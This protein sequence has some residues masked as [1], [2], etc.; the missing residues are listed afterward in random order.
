MPVIV[1]HIDLVDTRPDRSI[2]ADSSGAAPQPDQASP[3][4]D[5][6]AAALRAVERRAARVRA[7]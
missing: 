1:D 4:L 3:S 2:P 7:D 5:R 6:T